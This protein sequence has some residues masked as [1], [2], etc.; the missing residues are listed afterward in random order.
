MSADCWGPRAGA[1]V[2]IARQPTKVSAKAIP[3]TFLSMEYRSFTSHMPGHSPTTCAIA[4][5]MLGGSSVPSEGYLAALHTFVIPALLLRAFR[6]W[7][8]DYQCRQASGHPGQLPLA[9]GLRPRVIPSR[10]VAPAE[11]GPCQR[12]AYAVLMSISGAVTG[13]SKPAAA[14]PVGKT[15]PLMGR[16]LATVACIGVARL[17]QQ[18]EDYGA[19]QPPTLRSAQRGFA[20]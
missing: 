13:T 19:V 7:S 17:F 16:V 12:L 3:I 9:C 5:P 20:G 10:P 6:D 8:C 18:F 14:I 15:S 4:V 2:A 11:E 1:P